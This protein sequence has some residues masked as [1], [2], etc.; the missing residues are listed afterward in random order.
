MQMLSLCMRVYCAIRRFGVPT[1]YCD[2]SFGSEEKKH[3]GSVHF[4]NVDLRISGSLRKR[5]RSMS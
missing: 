1:S 3:A 2:Q 5:M 4:N